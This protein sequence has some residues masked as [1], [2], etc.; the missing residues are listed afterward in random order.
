LRLSAAPSKP[1]AEGKSIQK[2]THLKFV[3]LQFPHRLRLATSSHYD[4]IRWENKMHC[5]R[6]LGDTVNCSCP[7]RPMERHSAFVPM[8]KICLCIMVMQSIALKTEGA[9]LCLHRCIKVFAR[10]FSSTKTSSGKQPIGDNLTEELSPDSSE[11]GNHIS[12]VKEACGVFE[13]FKACSHTCSTSLQLSV[14]ED[15]FDG[16]N[17]MC[18]ERKNRFLKH[19]SCLEDK[20]KR[21][22]RLCKNEIKLI[23][24]A[25][26]SMKHMM[27]ANS[28]QLESSLQD[29]CRN[30]SRLV[31][32]FIPA[33]I[34]ICGVDAADLMRDFILLTFGKKYALHPMDKAY[35][36][37][38]NTAC[39][40][41]LRLLRRT[42]YP[43]KNFMSSDIVKYSFTTN[44]NWNELENFP[45]NM[46]ERKRLTVRKA[47][48]NSETMKTASALI[49]FIIAFVPLTICMD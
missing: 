6:E 12:S 39:S 23:E 45:V 43:Q 22:S 26:E 37:E 15:A 48:V 30:T 21:I 38:E 27:T 10:R 17:F 47:R 32:C 7:A 5:R 29:L 11:Q 18:F 46:D 36:P 14:L 31:Q 40:S 20:D 49:V 9:D 33:I 25:M 1:L 24:L 34:A 8:L 2:Q 28:L 4:T 41:L 42:P 16:L 13:E 35:S 44:S 19:A 3:Y